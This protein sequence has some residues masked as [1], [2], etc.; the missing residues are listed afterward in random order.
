MSQ[1]ARIVERKS[2][3]YVLWK[4]D[5]DGAWED[6]IWVPGDTETSTINLH[7]QPMSDKEIKS[8]PEGYRSEEWLNFWT[9]EEI[10][11]KEQF[12][13]AG[14]IFTIE[15]FSYWGP[16]TEGKAFRSGEADNIEDE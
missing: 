16:Y 11:G 7:L 6:G 9:T 4:E 2:N 3:P 5:S 10:Q 8:L 15:S 14:K 12:I 13:R 1:I